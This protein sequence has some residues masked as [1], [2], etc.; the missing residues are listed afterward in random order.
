MNKA[1]DM[2]K[3]FEG[4]SLK[5]Y[6]CP[7]GLWTI[8]YG[9]V[10][11]PNEPKII[12]LEQAENYLD[13]DIQTI[14]NKVLCLVKVTL[15]DNQLSALISFV[16]NVGAGAL[17]SS[18]LLKKLNKKLYAEASAEFLKWDKA[19]VN[20]TLK[21]LPGLTTRRNAEMRLFLS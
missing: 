8:G 9:H 10:I 6:K 17:A 12:S 18:T 20:G 13:K 19:K 5:A 4:L 2:I 14:K 15:T 11:K 3:H 16:Y 7:A 21:A 1:K